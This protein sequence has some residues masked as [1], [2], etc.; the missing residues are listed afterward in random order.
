[1]FKV[2]DKVR[3]LRE[4][5]SG[6]VT[7]IIDHNLVAVTDE[8]GFEIPVSIRELVPI[9]KDEQKHFQN[10]DSAEFEKEIIAT[11]SHQG[12]FI[13]F[14]Q[15][16]KLKNLYNLFFI[17]SSDFDLL[18]SYSHHTDTEL[19]GQCALIL[20]KQS[21]QKLGTFNIQDF[22]KWPK[23]NFQVLFHR[24]DKF[25]A[26]NPFIRSIKIKGANFFG[27]LEQVP[28]MEKKGHLWQLDEQGQGAHFEIGDKLNP[29]K[30]NNFDQF[31]PENEVDLHIEALRTDA[32][33]MNVEDIFSYQ[34]SYF[35]KCF[36]AALIHNYPKI[37]FIHGVGN[38]TLRNAIHK[39]IS[40]HPHVKTFKDAQKEK[41]GYGAT[42]IFF[43]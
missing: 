31:I 35:H 30:K 14:I 32:N 40:K 6:I 37:I 3:F 20:Q 12:I 17:N 38:G 16:E 7:R 13:A 21:F 18:L 24:N 19:I 10:S 34:L 9:S 4:P 2:G 27:R 28:L 33:K 43:N 36:E 15:E 41:F 39:I 22:E 1:M 42:E 26:L 29:V 5:I 23:L 11:L 25:N 8:N